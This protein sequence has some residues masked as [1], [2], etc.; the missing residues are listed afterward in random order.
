MVSRATIL[1]MGRRLDLFPEKPSHGQRRYLWDEWTDGSVW[2]IQRGEDYDVATENMRVNLH[3]KADSLRCKVRTRKFG[4]GDQGEGLIFQFYH[5]EREAEVTVHSDNTDAVMQLLYHDALEIYE[6]ARSEV[7]I[8][9]KDGS[10]QKYAANRYKQQIDKAYGDGQLVSAID[11]IVSRH[12]QGFGHLE[13]AER[14][15]LMVETLV[16]N[17]GKPYHEFFS[18]ETVRMARERMAQYWVR[19]SQPPI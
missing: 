6:R 14:P 12:T 8:P 16:L 7:T 19:H 18:A 4:D 1:I 9:R 13:A 2:E 17:V 3:I 11:R 5:P 15:D 10:R